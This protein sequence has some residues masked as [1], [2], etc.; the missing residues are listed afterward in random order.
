MSL[1][2]LPPRPP[3][4]PLPPCCDG[5]QSGM[6]ARA[7]SAKEGGGRGGQREGGG[8]G[9]QRAKEGGSCATLRWHSISASNTRDAAGYHFKPRQLH[10]S[11]CKTYASSSVASATQRKPTVPARSYPPSNKRYLPRMRDKRW[12]AFSLV[13][14]WQI[15]SDHLHFFQKILP[16]ALVVAAQLD[17]V[18]KVP[19]A[20]GGAVVA[21][22]LQQLTP[23]VAVAVR[24]GKLLRRQ[25]RGCT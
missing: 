20:A 8:E 22:A 10:Y 11:C 13:S 15:R 19:P 4:L 6:Q 24:V 21:A 12:R 16:D 25:A 9:G 18:P 1:C 2:P 17:A 7:A 3:P 5:L 23:C 14:H